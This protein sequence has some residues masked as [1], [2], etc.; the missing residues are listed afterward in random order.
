MLVTLNYRLGPFGFMAHPGLSAESPEGVSGN[1]GLLDMAAALALGAGATSPR[2]A[3]T[4][5]R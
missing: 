1:Y 5:S 4:R 3:A 2:S